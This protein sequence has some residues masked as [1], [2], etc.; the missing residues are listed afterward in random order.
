M[1]LLA[2]ILTIVGGYLAD[3]IL[4]INMEWPDAGAIFAI[5]IMGAFIL[6][7]LDEK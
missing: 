1:N 3:G 2:F 7:K 6:K 5:A 4:G